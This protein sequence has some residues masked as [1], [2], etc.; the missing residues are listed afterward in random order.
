MHF[1]LFFG[2]GKLSLKSSEALTLWLLVECGLCGW[3]WGGVGGVQLLLQEDNMKIPASVW[4][5]GAATALC[6]PKAAPQ[7][8]L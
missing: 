5:N 2:P 8:S 4:N 1:L 3:V 7:G 6:P